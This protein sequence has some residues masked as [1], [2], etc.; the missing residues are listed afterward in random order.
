MES[1]NWIG[2]NWDGILVAYFAAVGL[3]SAIVKLTPTI[4]DDIWLKKV[5]RFV[6]KFIALNR[7]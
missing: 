1:I 2:T 5:I 6:G 7:K 3:A 4:S